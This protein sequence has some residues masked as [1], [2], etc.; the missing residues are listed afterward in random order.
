MK[1]ILVMLVAMAMAM[2]CLSAW[3]E[4]G[5]VELYKSDFTAEDMEGWFANCATGA[6]T[7][8]GAFRITGRT[9]D[10]N[11]PKRVFGLKDGIEYKVTVEVYQDAVESATFKISVE[12][13]GAN[14]VNLLVAEVPK[15]EWTSLEV[16]FTLEKYNEYS[17]YVETEGFANIDYEI[18]DF[19]ILGP[20]G[21]L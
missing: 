7:E 12:Q 11:A 16:T 19:T 10:W 6:V 1:K 3:A 21:A 15:G 8:E 20:E 17:L 14:W 18:R 5:L 13:D 4:D 2:G 9:A